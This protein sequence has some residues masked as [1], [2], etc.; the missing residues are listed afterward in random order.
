MELCGRKTPRRD[1]G[2][3]NCLR[4]SGLQLIY[5][6]FSQEEHEFDKIIDE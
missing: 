4:D 1:R 2:K 5:L 3:Q 6:A